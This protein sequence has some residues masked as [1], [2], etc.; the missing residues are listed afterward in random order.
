MSIPLA[1]HMT[2]RFARKVVPT[3][4][5]QYIQRFTETGFFNTNLLID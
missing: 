5:H 1:N 3:W 2:L 4:R